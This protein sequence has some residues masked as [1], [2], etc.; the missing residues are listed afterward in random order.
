M[1]SASHLQ[2]EIKSHYGFDL[3]RENK[4]H[5]ESKLHHERVLNMFSTKSRLL[6]SRGF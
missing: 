2:R 5:R 1:C 3:Q 4:S 6:K